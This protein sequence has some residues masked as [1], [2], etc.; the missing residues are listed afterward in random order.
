[1]LKVDIRIVNYPYR[2][3]VALDRTGDRD[4]FILRNPVHC[5]LVVVADRYICF[6]RIGTSRPQ[7]SIETIASFD[8]WSGTIEN[9]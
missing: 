8:K 9:H 2:G 4:G 6:K 1:M 5:G 3:R 7:R